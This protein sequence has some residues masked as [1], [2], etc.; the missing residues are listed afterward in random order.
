MD[1]ALDGDNWTQATLS[2]YGFANLSELQ[3]T[4]LD[5]VRHG[6]QTISKAG[7]SCSRHPNTRR[8]C[9]RFI[10]TAIP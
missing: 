10:R 3:N 4:W 1:A 9:C 6:S 2:H 8:I 7:D 5:W